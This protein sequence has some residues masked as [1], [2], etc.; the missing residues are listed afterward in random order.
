MAFLPAGDV[1]HRAARGDPPRLPDREPSRP[2]AARGSTTSRSRVADLDRVLESPRRGEG[3]HPR[4]RAARPG[5]G[6]HAGRVPAPARH[7]GRAGR[8]RREDLAAA[9]TGSGDGLHPGDAVLAYLRDPPRSCGA[10]CAAR[11]GGGRARGVDL[12]SFDDWIAQVERGEEGIGP[13]VLFLPDA[14]RREAPARPQERS[15]FP[16]LSERF[17]RRVRAA[18]CSRSCGSAEVRP[19]R[20]RRGPGPGAWRGR[21]PGRRHAAAPSGPRRRAA[22]ARRGRCWPWCA[23]ASPR[24]RPPAPPP[25]PGCARRS[26]RAPFEVGLGEQ[27]AELVAAVAAGQVRPTQGRA[28]HRTQGAQVAIARRG[29]RAGR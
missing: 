3:G 1:A 2:R 11:R 20:E 4:R 16:S 13:S 15:S 22:G 6:G 21:G 29:A 5:A 14:A 26:V 28:Q 27:D 18:P 10:C 24:R 19:R 23:R 12:A 8:A 25:P 7:G 9:R 17:E